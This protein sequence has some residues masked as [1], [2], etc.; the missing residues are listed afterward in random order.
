MFLERAIALSFANSERLSLISKRVVFDFLF[1]VKLYG[2][3]NKVD[4]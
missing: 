4:K 1:M 2:H 3:D